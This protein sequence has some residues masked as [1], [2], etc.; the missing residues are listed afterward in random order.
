VSEPKWVTVEDCIL[1]NAAALAGRSENHFLRDRGSLEAAVARP[2]NQYAYQGETS[3]ARLALHLVYGIGKAHAF[4]QG[5]KRT[6]WGAA[7]FFIRLNGFHVRP[8]FEQQD[9]MKDLVETLIVDGTGLDELQTM[10]EQVMVP[11]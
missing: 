10:I 3:I 5:N 7:I 11:V 6:A 8:T 1:V 9:K 4:E 2:I